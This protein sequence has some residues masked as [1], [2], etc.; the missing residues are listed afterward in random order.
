MDIKIIFIAY[1]NEYLQM[2]WELNVHGWD[3]ETILE[4]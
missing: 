1:T 2:S 3:K 4:W